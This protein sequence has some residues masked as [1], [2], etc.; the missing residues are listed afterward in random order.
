[1]DGGLTGII[2]GDLEGPLTRVSR[3]RILTCRISQKRCVLGTKL[4]KNS[5]RKPYTIYWMVYSMTLSDL[6][7][8]FQGHDNFR[9][10]LS[11]KRHEIE[12]IERQQ[13]VICALSNGD[14][15]N[16]FDGP[17]TRFSKSRH[18]WSR[19][20]LLFFFRAQRNSCNVT[21]FTF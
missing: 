13:E 10:W 21:F 11:Q 1:M 19:I 6:W 2:F 18:F 20:C 12:T 14:I 3:S 16:E 15:S 5:N 9:H 7:P 17:L 8:Q 4:L